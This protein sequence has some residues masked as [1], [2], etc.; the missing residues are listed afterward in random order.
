MAKNDELEKLGEATKNLNKVTANL[1][2]FNETAAYE[3]GG[4]LVG[5]L[6]GGFQP[7]IQSLESLP[8]VQ[9]IG[10]IGNILGK[11][12]FS[13]VREK[14][15]MELLRKNMGL[16]KE[17]FDVLKEQR[18]VLDAQKKR[19]DE[20]SAAS[21]N[22]L[23]FPAKMEGQF[24][25]LQIDPEVL[26][27]LS[28]QE[29]IELQRQHL[30]EVAE[31]K[32]DADNRFAKEEE[33]NDTFQE[34]VK[35]Q[36]KNLELLRLIGEE[37]QKGNAARE[38]EVANE[39]ARADKKNTTL[40]EK[41][42]G[43]I[44]GLKD[45]LLKGLA[46]LKDKGIGALGI[47]AGVVGG[48]FVGISAFFTSLAAEFA[49]LKKAL[50]GINI[51]FFKPIVDFFNKIL[52]RGQLFAS[53]KNMPMLGK[54]LDLVVKYFN[55]LGK[56]GSG[57]VSA[58]GK[59]GQFFKPVV[60]FFK[61]VAS[62]FAGI[63][64][65][66]SAGGPFISAMAPI[67]SF[68]AKAGALL[69]KIFLPFTILKG[70]FDFFGSAS[71]EYQ[72]SGSIINA[73][74]AGI[75][76]A[77]GGFFGILL[78]LPKSII[79]W[80]FEAFL[81]EGNIISTTLDSF[82]FT[83]V[84]KEIVDYG[85]RIILSPIT[86]VKNLLSELFDSTLGIFSNFF[87]I[88]KGIFTLDIGLIGDGVFGL[89][90]GIWDL[91][92]APFR[93]VFDTVASIF[94]FD[95]TSLIESLP[96]G[97]T[98][99]KL[100]RGVGSFFFGDDE[101]KK[102]AEAEK[103]A[104]EQRLKRAERQQSMRKAAEAQGNY[105]LVVDGVEQGAD[106]RAARIAAKDDEIKTF[107]A[108]QGE[109]QMELDRLAEIDTLPEYF[110]QLKSSL[111]TALFGADEEKIMVLKEKQGAALE[112]QGRIFENMVAQG[113]MTEEEKALKLKETVDEYDNL[114][115]EEQSKGIGLFGTI[116]QGVMTSFGQGAANVGKFFT[117]TFSFSEEDMT[118]SG[119]TVKM[120]DIISSPYNA[121]VNFVSGSFGFGEDEEGQIQPFSIGELVME[122]VNKIVDFFT[123]LFDFDFTEIIK[124]IP[125]AG[126]ILDF[127][128]FG[129]EGTIAQQIK[130]A[131]DRIARSEAGENVY[132]GG[133]AGGRNRDRQ[134]I[135][136]LLQ[137][138]RE[139]DTE[140]GVAPVIIQDNSSR[141][142]TSTS[143]STVQM[144]PVRDVSPPVGTL[145]T[146]GAI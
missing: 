138:Q 124:K 4:V 49:V 13:K 116:S 40:L 36:Q 1:Q 37:G 121:A 30:D 5:E 22:I 64:K 117:N 130:E 100:L 7:I 146:A 18:K 54:F 134:E 12:L 9:A 10:K 139:L 89:L 74:T 41:I 122:G 110:G 70:L 61:K 140:G 29:L 11:S 72:D 88:V 73:I 129:D 104:G 35:D 141:V 90:G 119:M 60:E 131:E 52:A 97:K 145:A 143:S 128:G 48:V 68:A 98:A 53:F 66:A 16:T 81:G 112:Q 65:F 14:K 25:N 67:L 132:F 109:L 6:K 142:T 91:I 56:I 51:K 125:G 127:L 133:E 23:G 85:L 103:E 137:E 86:F 114:I 93:A 47:L 144:R 39:K 19:N 33:Y 24:K 126:A 102:I 57:F 77:I 95:F 43:G 26:K 34:A 107:G 78:D 82:S 115:L 21:E 32:Q 55:F 27:T 113:F 76:G 2:K 46:A 45:G 96:G 118:A 108:R 87:D 136:R 20:L 123:N 71:E 62:F 42:A 28:P 8:G 3:V 94:D 31:S 120:I 83:D 135:E 63:T 101:E 84:I 17:E 44:T 38:K 99:M 69:G 59:V 50:T 79:S 111:G 106:V 92:T 58:V 80:L 75:G 15:Q 105:S